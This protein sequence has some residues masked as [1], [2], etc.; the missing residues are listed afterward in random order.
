MMQFLL[1]IT[2]SC[3]PHANVLSLFTLV[4]SMAPKHKFTLSRNLLRS[5]ASSF[6]DPTPFH[7][8]F[9]DKDA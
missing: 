1:H 4:V 7:L 2:C 6:S 3:I 8:R 5:G 9:R